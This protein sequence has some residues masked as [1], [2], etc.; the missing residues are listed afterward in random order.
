MTK[1]QPLSDPTKYQFKWIP[2]DGVDNESAIVHGS[3]AKTPQ[4]LYAALVEQL[5][6]TRGADA[7]ASLLAEKLGLP[8]PDPNVI[9]TVARWLD[10]QTDD[11]I[12]LVVVRR[13]RGKTMTKRVNDVA[14]AKA[15]IRSQQKLGRKRLSKEEV[16]EIADQ[17]EISDAK[18][19]KV[20]S[21]IRK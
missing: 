6:E 4:E 14:I 20:I 1:R 17:F 3:G 11:Y 5:F 15:I 2:L 16:G 7:V 18:V 21:Q 8:D 13:R 10:P 9:A 12:K 19:R